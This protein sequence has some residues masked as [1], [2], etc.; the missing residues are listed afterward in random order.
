[1]TMLT[2][3][4]M[5]IGKWPTWLQNFSLV[6]DILFPLLKGLGGSF[7]N[8][9]TTDDNERGRGKEREEREETQGERGETRGE[10][11]KEE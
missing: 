2:L 11:T 7:L 9:T 10:K 3:Y 6:P 1:M 5:D 8:C 4:D